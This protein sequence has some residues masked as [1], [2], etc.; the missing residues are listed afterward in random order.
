[1][2][3]II[4]YDAHNETHTPSKRESETDC[5]INYIEGAIMG[6]VLDG[7][8]SY[9]RRH[10]ATLARGPRTACHPR[11]LYWIGPAA[12]CIPRRDRESRL[13]PPASEDRI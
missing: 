12:A 5:L 13:R 10:M 2:Q 11:R 6:S 1:M 9:V 7:C 4:A 3:T 8:M